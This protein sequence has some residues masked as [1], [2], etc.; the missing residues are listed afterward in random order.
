MDQLIEIKKK[1]FAR[2]VASLE[3]GLTMNIDPVAVRDTAL[4]RFIFSS[5]LS[6]KVTR[7]HVTQIGGAEVVMSKDAYRAAQ[8][9]QLLSPEETE[10]ALAMVDDRNRLAHDYSEEFAQ[11]LF[12]RV[13]NLYA[14]L[15]RTILTRI[16]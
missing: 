3:Q 7:L 9:M 6:W 8:K 15:M 13:K 4:M 14:P 2:A 10:I 12:E 16:R 1:E 5:E 11:K